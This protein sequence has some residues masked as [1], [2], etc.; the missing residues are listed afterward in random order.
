MRY[1]GLGFAAVL[2]VCLGAIVVAM[3]G[4]PQA[5]LTHWAVQQPAQAAPTGHESDQAAG[6]RSAA[7]RSGGAQ[8]SGIAVPPG[9]GSSPTQGASP[10]ADPSPSTSPTAGPSGTAT[11][12]GSPVP[13][14]KAGKT[15]PGHTKSPNP[16]KSASV[17]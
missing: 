5:P 6:H 7:G 2:A 17:A 13:T 1:A 12:S 8:P 4:G 16:R 14:N 10:T 15:P 3:T 9:Q 11:A